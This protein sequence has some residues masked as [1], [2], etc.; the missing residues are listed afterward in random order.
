LI[1]NRS[2]AALLLLLTAAAP[3]LAAAQEDAS[4]PITEGY[5]IRGGDCSP[6][7]LA[8][9]NDP[10]IDTKDRLTNLSTNCEQAKESGSSGLEKAIDKL[11]A[12]TWSKGCATTVS[13]L[14]KLDSK[15]QVVPTPN[16][17]NKYHCDLRVITPDKAS[18]AF[19]MGGW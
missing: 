2:F 12:T 16:G 10:P 5:V 8:K 14:M 15:T 17:S 1:V 3:L 7:G 4:A 19:Q 6:K 13:Q 11:K 18:T 9:G